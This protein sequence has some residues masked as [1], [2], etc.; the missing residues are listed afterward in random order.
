[1]FCF[2]FKRVAGACCQVGAGEVRLLVWNQIPG[3]S[4]SQW[5]PSY[6]DDRGTLVALVHCIDARYVAALLY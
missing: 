1:M 6:I 2:V 3:M 5:L 4:E